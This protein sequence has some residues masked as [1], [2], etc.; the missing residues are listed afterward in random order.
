MHYTKTIASF[1][2]VLNERKKKNA[3]FTNEF[4][5]R[6]GF[7]PQIFYSQQKVA[8]ILLLSAYFLQ[9]THGIFTYLYLYVYIINSML[10]NIWRFLMCLLTPI[11]RIQKCKM[12]L[13]ATKIFMNPKLYALT[14]FSVRS[15]PINLQRQV[16]S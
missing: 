9:Q 14:Y 2:L 16:Y 15:I 1:L 8:D 3:T 5:K 10:P 4:N 12:K 6:T 13:L 7:Y 11:I